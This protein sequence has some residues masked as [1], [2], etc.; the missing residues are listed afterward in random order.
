MEIS[1]AILAANQ[2]TPSN[3]KPG[4]SAVDTGK[5]NVTDIRAVPLAKRVEHVLTNNIYS[6]S[7]E[8]ALNHTTFK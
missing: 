2:T 7:I 5:Y 3:N 1:K 4:V 8:N 6:L